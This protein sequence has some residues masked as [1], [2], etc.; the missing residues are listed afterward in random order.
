Q[1]GVTPRTFANAISPRYFEVMRMAV[2]G[3]RAFG[4]AG[5]QTA[6]RGAIVHPTFAPQFFGTQNPVGP[7]LGRGAPARQRRAG[8]G[9]VEDAK[10]VDLREDRRPMLYVPYPQS[11]Q[12]ALRE[13]EV[14]TS[15][16]PTTVAATVRRELAAVDSRLAIVGMMALRDRVDA[17]IA[18]ER[19][20]TR[21]SAGFGLIAL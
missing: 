15:A 5:H 11:R 13:L 1:P 12:Q 20:V 9:V 17:S 21:L 16:A 3:G 6:P 19:M 14:R 8:A 2:T 10:Y 7:P 4:G 18:P